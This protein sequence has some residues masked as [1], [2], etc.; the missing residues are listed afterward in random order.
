MKKGYTTNG[1]NETGNIIWNSN[2]T[3]TDLVFIGNDGYE[4]DKWGKFTVQSFSDNQWNEIENGICDTETEAVECVETL[5]ADGFYEE[6]NI[7]YTK[8]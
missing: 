5:N 6:G 4:S 8:I 7:I 2:A 3:G 1:E